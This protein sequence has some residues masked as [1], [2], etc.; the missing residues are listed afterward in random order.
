[1]AIPAAAVPVVTHRARVDTASTP[2]RPRFGPRST[3]DRPAVDPRA[4]R[5][6]QTHRLPGLLMVARRT[7]NEKQALRCSSRRLRARRRHLAQRARLAT[8]SRAEPGPIPHLPGLD[9]A[10]L[11][12]C[13]STLRRRCGVPPA[14]F[15]RRSASYGSESVTCLAPGARAHDSMLL[16]HRRGRERER[17]STAGGADVEAGGAGPFATPAAPFRARWARCS[18]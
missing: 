15:R 3:S 4:A 18:P 5:A 10:G 9:N 1:M 12:R 16:P 7:A 6:A 13:S 11:R 14:I 17:E 2:H 8:P